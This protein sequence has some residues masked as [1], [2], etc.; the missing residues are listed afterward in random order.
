MSTAGESRLEPSAETLQRL[1]RT[2]RHEVGDLLQTVYSSAAILQTRL[3]PGASVERRLLDDLHNQAETCKH[4]LDALH[5]LACP[6][7]LNAAPTD[8]AG[9]L[10]GLAA[11]LGPRF[12]RLRLTVEAPPALPVTADAQRLQ[13]LAYLLTVNACLAA[14]RQV[15]LRAADEP[16]GVFFAVADDGPGVAPEQLAWL[17]RPFATTHNAQFGLG[18]ALADRV[19][20]LHGG[21]AEAG[22]Q[23]DGGCRVAVH[24]P[25]APPES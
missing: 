22:N 11:R 17:A 16:G 3:P 15:A 1:A 14:R 8:L 4:K 24:L 2:L 20:R 25:A 9:L 21:R 23:P 6:A 19:A 13:Q 12:P 10:V 7:A 18:L 5:D